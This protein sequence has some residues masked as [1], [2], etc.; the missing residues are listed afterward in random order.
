MIRSGLIV[1]A[2]AAVLL[3]GAAGPANLV[4]HR[5]LYVLSPET[6][7]QGSHE[8][9][10]SGEMGVDRSRSCAGWTFEHRSL[11]ELALPSDVPSVW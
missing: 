10:V 2:V 3:T 5:A 1:V 11:M 9:S 7:D 8:A 4:S 6:A